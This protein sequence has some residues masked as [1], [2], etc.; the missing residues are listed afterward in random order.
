MFEDSDEPFIRTSKALEY[1]IENV[2]GK[3]FLVGFTKIFG[4][5]K[6]SRE[7]DFLL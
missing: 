1:W 2:V 3:N 7:A 4:Q 5:G 6:N